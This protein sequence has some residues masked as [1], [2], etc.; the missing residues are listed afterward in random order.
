MAEKKAPLSELIYDAE[1]LKNRFPNLNRLRT[2]IETNEVLTKLYQDFTD[3]L[4]SREG[5]TN[6]IT[7][8]FSFEERLFPIEFNN[9]YVIDGKIIKLQY[10]THHRLNNDPSSEP[11]R[12][13]LSFSGPDKERDKLFTVFSEWLTN[14]KMQE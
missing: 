3:Y 10:S 11:K 12:R 8:E 14:L 1:N 5:E 6:F 4:N 7:D 2:T 13:Y 9:L